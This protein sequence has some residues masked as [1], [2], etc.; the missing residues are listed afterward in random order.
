MLD[1]EKE[2][3]KTLLDEVKNAE[4]EAQ[5]DWTDSAKATLND[6]INNFKTAINSFEVP[7]L[8]SYFPTSSEN[9]MKIDTE[10]LASDQ[11]LREISRKL[12]GKYRN[13]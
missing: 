12:D 2:I 3:A 10:G 1:Q 7:S 13:E 4:L 6:F 11:V 5:A 9:G 8:S